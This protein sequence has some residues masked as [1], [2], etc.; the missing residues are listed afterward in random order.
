MLTPDLRNKTH[1]KQGPSVDSK[2]KKKE[3]VG[4]QSPKFKPPFTDDGHYCRTFLFQWLRWR[5]KR[6]TQIPTIR[7]YF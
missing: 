5:E 1:K 4:E 2:K 3:K 6:T 7:C